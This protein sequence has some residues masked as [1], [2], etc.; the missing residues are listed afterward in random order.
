[1]P[2]YIFNCTNKNI[3]SLYNETE[4]TD[5]SNNLYKSYP[6]I[7]LM[8]NNIVEVNKYNFIMFTDMQVIDLSYNKLT[9]IEY[10]LFKF[11]KKLEWITLTNNS[12]KDFNL[13]LNN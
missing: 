8:Y 1:M 6:T 10:D 13:N 7:L 9:I 4:F 11:N 5:E 3:L 2:K 12:I